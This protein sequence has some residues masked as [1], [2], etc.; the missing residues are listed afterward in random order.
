MSVAR[1]IDLTSSRSPSSGSA[2]RSSSNV[3]AALLPA[4]AV[5]MAAL[6]T[7]AYVYLGTGAG[8]GPPDPTEQWTD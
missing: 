7:G 6:L 5:V 8:D 3:R 4:L 2:E 1:T